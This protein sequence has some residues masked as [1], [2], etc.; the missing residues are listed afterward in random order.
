MT[1]NRAPIWTRRDVLSRFSAVAGAGLLGLRGRPATAEPSLETTT[2]R[3]VKIPSICQAPQYMAEELL[4][5]EGF[6]DVQYIEKPG[7]V[8]IQEALASGEADVNNLFAGPLIRQVDAGDPI[9]IL[10]GLHIGC[11]ELFGTDRVANLRDLKGKSLAVWQLGSVQHVFLATIL[12]HV[13][14]DPESEV[15][16]VTEPPNVAKQLFA[17]GKVDAYLG[18]PPDPQELRARRI[19]HVLLDSTVDSPWH[20]YFCCLL[21][22]NRD[23]VRNNPN[24]TKRAL[25]AILKA[26]AI[27]S[28]EPERA[29]RF[30]VD[31][32]FTA[33]Y[34]YALENMRTIPYGQWRNF[35]AEDTVRFYSLRLREAGLIDSTPNRIIA[36]GT[37]WRFI[38]Q[39]KRELKV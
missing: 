39:L 23:F 2:I 31:R 26:N 4:L 20:Q 34:E 5:A 30:I 3:L 7:T 10:G 17:Q 11:F 32:G 18:F 14:V 16:W 24:A 15:N 9:V 36:E 27:C 6:T 29:A 13:G 1:C 19:G 12:A 22:G 25:R 28:L 35:S 37:D 33:S 21:A 38:E 8:G